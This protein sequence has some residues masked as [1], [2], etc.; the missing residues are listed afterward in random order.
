MT[1]DRALR[2]N[3]WV[4][5]SFRRIAGRMVLA[6]GVA[7]VLILVT[8]SDGGSD[9]PVRW[10]VDP[11]ALAATASIEVTLARGDQI[12]AV[13][14]GGGDRVLELSTPPPR[15]AV[16][17]TV[18][19]IGVDGARRVVHEARP[20]PGSTVVVELGVTPE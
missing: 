19:A 4:T 20:G 14:S 10:Q 2:Y 5:L 11:R 16:T 3:P 6:A 8:R 18:I 13:A 9:R 17:I 12:L 7:A 15:A 1:G